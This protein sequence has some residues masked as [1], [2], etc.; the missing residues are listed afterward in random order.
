M[1]NTNT[2]LFPSVPPVAIPNSEPAESLH[3]ALAHSHH[4]AAFEI[5]DLV[6]GS[7][8]SSW[9]TIERF[10]ESSAIYENPI[11]TATSRSVIADIHTLSNQLARLNIPKPLSVLFALFGLERTGRWADPW[12]RAI[13]V[14]NEIGDVCES[15]SFGEYS[16]YWRSFS[17]PLGAST[18]SFL[19]SCLY[20]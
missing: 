7:T 12:F 16:K 11:L 17:S 13:R 15:D 1:M 19:T 10:Y 9:D 3:N 6:Y 14:W 20:E 18:S 8:P 2:V 4:S 5:C